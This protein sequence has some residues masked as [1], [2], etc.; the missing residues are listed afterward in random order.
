MC[1]FGLWMGLGVFMLAVSWE[2]FWRMGKASVS[3]EV[4]CEGEMIN[5]EKEAIEEETVKKET[6]VRQGKE[7]GEGERFGI[8]LRIQDGKIVFF[9]EKEESVSGR[10]K[11]KVK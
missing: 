6:G 2:L 1:S 3:D 4:L 7:A 10:Y 8:E 5:R 11:I 9:R